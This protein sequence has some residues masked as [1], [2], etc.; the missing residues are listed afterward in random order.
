MASHPNQLNDRIKLRGLSR[1]PYARIVSLP[2]YTRYLG[3]TIRIGLNLLQLRLYISLDRFFT[4]AAITVNNQ[5]LMQK[6][7]THRL[8]NRMYKS[9]TQS[10]WD[11][12]GFTRP[13]KIFAIMEKILQTTFLLRRRCFYIRV[14]NLSPKE[15][16]E[17]RH[18]FG[19]S[20]VQLDI[21]IA[22]TS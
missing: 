22:Y 5:H 10:Q 9:F 19:C 3:T 7:C 16:S 21:C 1:I 20:S 12:Q 11:I 14:S 2:V 6:K 13:L 15:R 18:T 17:E 4:P 8:K